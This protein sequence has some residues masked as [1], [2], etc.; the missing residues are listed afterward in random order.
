MDRNKLAEII[1]KFLT[2]NE[3]GYYC[4]QFADYLIAND[5]GDITA[6]KHK[7]EV[8]EEENNRVNDQL[9]IL[10]EAL[11]ICA[12]EHCKEPTD[13]VGKAMKKLCC[14]VCYKVLEELPKIDTLGNRYC[15]K[16]Y[17]EHCKQ[18]AAEARLKELEEGK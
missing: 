10:H 18:Q 6:E 15:K 9:Q 1:D 11:G 13:Y 2:E 4:E 16:H 7:A 5:I 17:E 12:R 8:A 3:D 14:C